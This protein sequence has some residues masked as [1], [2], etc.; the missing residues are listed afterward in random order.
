MDKSKNGLFITF[1]GGEG[2]GKS[3]HSK[4]LEKY[5]KGKGYNVLLTRE[6]G[7]TKL[8]KNIRDILLS[9]KTILADG[10]ELMLFAADR[11]EHVDKVIKPELQNGKIVICDRFTDSTTAYQIGGRGVAEDM[12]RYINC[13]SSEGLIPDRTI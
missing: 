5:L 7:G 3:T 6:P 11:L 4:M 13:I 2:C 1:E 9:E 12:V 10:T 8:G